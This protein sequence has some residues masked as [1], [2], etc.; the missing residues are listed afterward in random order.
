MNGSCQAKG[1][2]AGFNELLGK[3]QEQAVAAVGLTEID[4]HTPVYLFQFFLLL[5]LCP[6]AKHR[7]IYN[8]SS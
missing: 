1:L 8:K 2:I 7:S 5:A 3:R 6:C 4:T